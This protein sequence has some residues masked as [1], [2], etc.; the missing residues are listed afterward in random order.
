MKR[1]CAESYT[2]VKCIDDESYIRKKV[3]FLLYLGERKRNL[4]NI[5][6]LIVNMNFVQNY[7]NKGIEIDNQ[8]RKFSLPS[9]L[10]IFILSFVC[11][12]SIKLINSLSTTCFYSISLFDYIIN[13]VDIQKFSSINN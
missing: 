3:F 8:L 9:N 10:I 7:I 1:T 4:M 13:K 11:E 6:I 2:I 5:F 12:K